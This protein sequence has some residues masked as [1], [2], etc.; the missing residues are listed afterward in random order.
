MP[1]FYDNLLVLCIAQLVIVMLISYGGRECKDHFRTSIGL[2]LSTGG[3]SHS[4]TVAYTL[5]P[6][7]KRVRQ[8]M[9]FVPVSRSITLVLIPPAS[10]GSVTKRKSF[11]L[12]YLHS[13]SVNFDLSVQY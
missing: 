13:A 3:F 2:F 10:N 7:E 8:L 1:N 12:S 11:L 4:S 6:R 5:F 9:T